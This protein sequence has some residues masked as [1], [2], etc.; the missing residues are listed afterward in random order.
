MKDHICLLAEQKAISAI[1]TESD[2]LDD[3]CPILC[4]RI[5]QRSPE[6]D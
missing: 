2:I 5:E 4:A 1:R 6:P 3:R